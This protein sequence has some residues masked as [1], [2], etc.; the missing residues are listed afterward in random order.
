MTP[1]FYGARRWRHKAFV[2]TSPCPDLSHVGPG[3]VDLLVLLRH[4]GHVGLRLKPGQQVHERLLLCW[5]GDRRSGQ[6]S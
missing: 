2:L 6:P 3:G 5:M 4:A 1:D